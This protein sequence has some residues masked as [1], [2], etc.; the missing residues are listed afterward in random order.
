MWRSLHL[1]FFLLKQAVITLLIEES[2]GPSPL[3][4]LLSHLSPKVFHVGTQFSYYSE[5]RINVGRVSPKRP[6][7]NDHRQD[8]SS[9]QVM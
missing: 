1:G 3:C 6:Q 4:G 7:L 5:G 9:I 8:V 2:F